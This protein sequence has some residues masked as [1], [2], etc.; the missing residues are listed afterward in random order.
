M[1]PCPVVGRVHDNVSSLYM[2]AVKHNTSSYL[3]STSNQWSTL[4]HEAMSNLLLHL[5]KAEAV[6]N[7]ATGLLYL[8]IRQQ[9]DHLVSLRAPNCLTT[10][11]DYLC[12]VGRFTR[13]NGCHVIFL[14]TE[15]NTLKPL[16][17]HAFSLSVSWLLY[18]R[19]W[20]VHRVRQ[21]GLFE[22]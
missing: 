5:V 10:Q 17:K 12:Q 13:E 7:L 14:K 19:V 1:S 18:R 21:R 16:S 22:K 4:I 3:F 6:C 8:W 2:I 9:E 15:L 11:T 20:R